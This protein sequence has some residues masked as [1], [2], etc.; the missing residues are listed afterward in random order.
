MSFTLKVSID[1]KEVGLRTEL[2]GLATHR[3]WVGDEEKPAEE[4]E[5]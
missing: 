4:I 5:K 2:W 3:S 1:G